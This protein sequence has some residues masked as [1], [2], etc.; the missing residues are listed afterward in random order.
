MVKYRL[1]DYKT[2]AEYVV[3]AKDKKDLRI[4][5]YGK[6]PEGNY[7]V[8]NRDGSTKYYLNVTKKGYE[9][10]KN[11]RPFLPKDQYDQ[12]YYYVGENRGFKRILQ[13][14]D[15]LLFSSPKRYDTIQDARK[16]AL[17]KSK[18]DWMMI[19][20]APFLS[21]DHSLA[22]HVFKGRKYLGCVEY[23]ILRGKDKGIHDYFDGLWY[24]V[25]HPK[26]PSPILA[27]GSIGTRPMKKRK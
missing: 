1:I 25:E 5:A 9:R 12:L 27:D 17:A 19:R 26:D 18:K 22:Q 24:P 14:E 13:G 11:A 6:V 2:D 21:V 20:E 3:E 16:G 8:V 10:A 23:N 15:P 7:K 4:Q